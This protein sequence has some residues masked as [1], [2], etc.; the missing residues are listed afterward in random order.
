MQIEGSSEEL[1]LV[2]PV[3]EEVECSFLCRVFRIG[4]IKQIL[5]AEQKLFVAQ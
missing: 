2:R 1:I 3:A 5:D 4:I